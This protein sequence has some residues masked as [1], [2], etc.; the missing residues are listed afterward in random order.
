[1]PK[2]NKILTDLRRATLELKKWMEKN[3][4]IDMMD[5]IFIENNI[6][7]LQMT[8]TTWKSRNPLRPVSEG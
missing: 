5:Q 2:R 1:M 7:M 4:Q 3:P 6:Q 8:Y